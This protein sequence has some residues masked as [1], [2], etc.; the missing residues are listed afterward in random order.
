MKKAAEGVVWEIGG[1]GMVVSLTV[2]ESPKSM[3]QLCP[4][5]SSNTRIFAFCIFIFLQLSLLQVIRL[6]AWW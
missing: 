2:V 4:C 3:G 6:Y 5:R 1:R